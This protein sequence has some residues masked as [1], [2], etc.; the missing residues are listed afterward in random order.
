MRGLLARHRRRRLATRTE[1]L[2]LFRVIRVSGVLWPGFSKRLDAHRRCGVTY[3]WGIPVGRFT[4]EQRRAAVDL[5]AGINLVYT[6][7][8]IIDRL[9]ARS[10]GSFDGEG[11]IAGRRFCR[12]RLVP[13]LLLE[14]ERAVQDAA[15]RSK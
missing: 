1:L 8:P 9:V 7:W 5:P 13:T 4:V 14:R 12:F 10:D 3:L 11:T 15:V 2:E 6:R